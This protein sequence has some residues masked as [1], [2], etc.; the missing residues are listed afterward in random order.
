MQS[1][2]TKKL[3]I[4]NSFLLVFLLIGFVFAWFASNYGNYVDGDQVEV[5][6]D[7]ALEISLTGEAGTWKSSLLLN[8]TGS[9]QVDFNNVEFKDI[10][11]S[12]DGSFLRPAL[13]QLDGYAE[14]KSGEAWS[15]PVLNKD[16]I[17]FD[18]YMRS[19]DKLNV[20]LGDGSTVT[21]TSSRLIGAN[22]ENK[23]MFGN[24]SKDLVVGAVRLGVNDRN[25]HLFTWIP[26]PNIYLNAGTST[27]ISNYTGLITT[28][29][30]STDTFTN[31]NPYVH[32]YY[33][34]Q[35]TATTDLDAEMT[36]TGDI[37]AESNE[38]KLVSLT[39][40]SNGYYQDKV[41]VYI[42]L[43][44]C[45]NEARRAFVGGNFKVSLALSSVDVTT[46]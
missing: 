28:A 1:K 14:V 32:T 17:K 27:P 8:G 41:T 37:V 4:A 34:A 44:G 33:A 9:G 11:G 6:A 20:Y 24:F 39:S 29:A 12:G 5:I 25:G 43:E 21:P 2:R 40:Q 36:V 30:K 26:R 23:S 3:I 45:D 13:N 15:T 22:A 46:P 19:S 7:S 42:W 18:L 31:G 38:Q 35:G 16:Y 10:T